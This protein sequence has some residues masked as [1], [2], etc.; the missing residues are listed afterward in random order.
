MPS[1]NITA[2][3]AGMAPRAEGPAGA[4]GQTLRKR[5]MSAAVLLPL[6]LGAVWLGGSF[7]AGLVGLFAIAMAWEWST[8]CE[9]GQGRLT[10]RILGVAPAGLAAILVVGLASLLAALDRFGPAIALLGLGA[11]AAA[12]IAGLVRGGR[13]AWH[14]LG[15]LYV[16]LPC[17]AIVWVRAQHDQGLATLLWLLA[18]VMAVDTGAFAAGRLIGGA[19]LAP[20]ISPNKT[21]AGLGGGVVAAMLIGWMA[22][23]WLG[24]PGALPLV[25]ISAILALVEQGGDLAESAFKRRFAVKDSSRLIPG[26]GGVLDRVDGLL[27]VSLAVGVAELFFGGLLAWTR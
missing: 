25:Q 1:E 4:R 9:S 18:L 21:W 8:I 11:V 17:I 5:F 20:R 24:L 3:T 26:H 13:G 16:G 7:W 15:V 27:A 6:A 12:A 22:A 10:R 19:K 23:F 2:A 14:G